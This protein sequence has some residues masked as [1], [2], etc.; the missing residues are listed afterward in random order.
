MR[1]WSRSIGSNSSWR[2][3]ARIRCYPC[4]TIFSIC[5]RSKR[6]DAAGAGAFRCANGGGGLRKG[7]GSEGSREKHRARVCG[8]GRGRPNRTTGG[9]RIT[10]K[11]GGAGLGLAITRRLVD[12]YAGQIHVESEPEKG[13][14]F[15]V[16]L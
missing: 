14:A 3:A 16:T 8:A 7:S 2:G 10:R 12:M 11:Y 1:G 9:F 6:E 15:I 13:S 5:P 4:L